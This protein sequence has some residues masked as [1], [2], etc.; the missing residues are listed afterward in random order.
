[1]QY[2]TP[3]YCEYTTLFTFDKSEV[4]LSGYCMLIVNI[5]TFYYT[6]RASFL[7]QGFL[8]FPDP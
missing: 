2:F 1:M 4:R 6:N 7:P 5:R 3:C 8:I